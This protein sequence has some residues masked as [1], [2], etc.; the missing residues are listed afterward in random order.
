MVVG[1][2]TCERCGAICKL[3]WQRRGF[4]KKSTAFALG[5]VCAQQHWSSVW[6]AVRVRYL[7]GHGSQAIQMKLLRAD[8]TLAPGGC[9]FVSSGSWIGVGTFLA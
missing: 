6:F 9:C 7:G 3:T 4:D 2:R 1:R 5:D 8:N